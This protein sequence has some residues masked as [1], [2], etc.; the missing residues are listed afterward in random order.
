MS[1]ERNWYEWGYQLADGEFVWQD[2]YGTDGSWTEPRPDLGVG[3]IDI[4]LGSEYDSI[5]SELDRAGLFSAV[6]VRRRV[7]ETREEAEKVDG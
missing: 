3:N 2:D 6:V 1:E 4:Y 5:R 7:R